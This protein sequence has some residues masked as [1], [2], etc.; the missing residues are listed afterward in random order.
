MQNSEVWVGQVTVQEAEPP[1][2]QIKPI[3]VTEMVGMQEQDK[4][5][6]FVKDLIKD[7]KRPTKKERRGLKKDSCINGEFCS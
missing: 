6:K 5:I 1:V 4:T 2:D 7:G 3:D